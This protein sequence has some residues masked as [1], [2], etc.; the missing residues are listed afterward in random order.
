MGT[1]ELTTMLDKSAQQGLFRLYPVL[2]EVTVSL[3]FKFSLASIQIL[4]RVPAALLSFGIPG[5]LDSCR[6][7]T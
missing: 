1:T 2:P 6:R 4:L 3:V 7:Q 5:F